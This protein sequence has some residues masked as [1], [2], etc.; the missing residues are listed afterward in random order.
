MNYLL[1]RLHYLLIKL[2]TCYSRFHTEFTFIRYRYYK[3]YKYTLYKLQVFTTL[4]NIVCHRQL[5]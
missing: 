1:I 2:V 4:N 5:F 3:Y